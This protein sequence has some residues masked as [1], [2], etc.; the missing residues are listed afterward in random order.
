MTEINKYFVMN[1]AGTCKNLEGLLEL[2]KVDDISAILIGSVTKQKRDGNSGEV[3]RT[4]PQGTLNSLGMNNL[5][6]DY[7]S[8]RMRDWAQEAH[9]KGK[10]FGVS[11][12]GV[13]SIEEYIL[14]AEECIRKNADFVELNGG[15]PNVWDTGRQHRILT[16]DLKAFEK[17][18]LGIKEYLPK[19]AKIYFKVSPISGPIYLQELACVINAF[20]IITGITTTNTFPNGH[21][22]DAGG[23][24]LIAVGKGLAG[25]S[26]TALKFI[27]KGQVLQW[28][29]YLS[30]EKQIIA[31]GGIDCGQDILDYSANGAVKFQI[32]TAFLNTG[33][34]IFGQVLAE[35]EELVENRK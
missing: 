32:G 16:F 3:Y 2:C 34:S 22:R 6:F 14:M 29:E 26:G 35:T 25:V 8:S 21:G 7:Y 11:V 23:K 30:A 10:Q 28:R 31:V 18:F 24:Q 5:G 15:C 4:F 17:L 1:A 27:S 19:D 13:E 9:A 20:P 33:A 12:A